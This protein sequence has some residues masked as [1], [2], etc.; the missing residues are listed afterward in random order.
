METTSGLVSPYQVL[1]QSAEVTLAHNLAGTADAR[2]A[3]KIIDFSDLANLL[4]AQLVRVRVPSNYE[5]LAFGLLMKKARLEV[6]PD[7]T[8]S[9]GRFALRFLKEAGIPY[10]TI[11]DSYLF[12]SPF[13]NVGG[14]IIDDEDLADALEAEA[15]Y[16]AKGKAAFRSYEEYRRRRLS[17]GV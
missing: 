4:E 9:V 2:P 5:Q 16:V 13:P 12:V 8:F 14:D 15:E 1:N 17:Q 10:D 11:A 7:H 3:P 6:F